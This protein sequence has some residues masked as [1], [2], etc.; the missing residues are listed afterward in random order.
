M[1][2]MLDD[3]YAL[4]RQVTLASGSSFALGMR[5]FPKRV[6]R[7]VYVLYAFFRRTDDIV[8]GGGAIDRQRAELAAWRGQV[9]AALGGGGMEPGGILLAVADTAHRHG[10]PARLFL[11]CIDACAG[12]L[13]PVRIADT[14]ELERYCDGVAGTVGEACLRIL[15]YDAPDLLELSV[16]NARAVQLTNILRDVDED[17]AHDRIY[18]PADLLAHH[19]VAAEDLRAGQRM[20]PVRAA[21]G[22]LADRAEALY[23]RAEPLFLM[24]RP[25]D[26]PAIVALTL[27]YRRLL[28]AL[29]AADF[30]PVDRQRSPGRCLGLIAAA[31]MARW[32]PTWRG[33]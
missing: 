27:R 29:R 20:Q 22:D 12:D 30:R 9:A 24:L 1:A 16:A 15:G 3:S 32:K 5:L 13:G 11:D 21:I 26:R 2:V 8:D 25:A 19:G 17:L 33:S 4:C 31:Q 23:G 14:A 6:R 10:L 7:S 28:E 18:L